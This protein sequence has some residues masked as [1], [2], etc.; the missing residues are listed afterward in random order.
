M[1]KF[2]GMGIADEEIVY[3]KGEGGGVGV[4]AEEHGGS[5]LSE[6]VLG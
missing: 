3:Y 6:V 5:G 4:E 2:G 1:A